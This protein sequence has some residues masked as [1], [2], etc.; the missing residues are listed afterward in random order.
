MF[1]PGLFLLVI[2]LLFVTEHTL[3]LNLIFHGLYPRKLS[4]LQGILLAPMIHG[5]LRHIFANSLPLFALGSLL[6]YFYPT[7]ALKVS[8]ISYLLPGIIVWFVGRSSYHVGA[9]AIIYSLAA[10]LFLSGLIRK[11]LGLMAVALL[12]AMEYGTMVWGIFPL[13]EGVSWE[14]HLAGMMTGLCLAGLYRNRG[15]KGYATYSQGLGYH[16]NEDSDEDAAR[17][18]PWDEYDVEGER[19]KNPDEKNDPPATIN[20]QGQ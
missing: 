13:E 5:G 20:N 14:S 3:D 19:K 11:H 4:G 9:S 12:V 2:W 8:A 7:L 1:F 17:A 6:F 16:L 10:F 18:L 15:P